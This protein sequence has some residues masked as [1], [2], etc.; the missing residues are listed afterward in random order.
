[1]A[2]RVATVVFSAGML[3]L[4]VA[5]YA[6]PDLP[7]RALELPRAEQRGRDRRR[8][9]DAPAAAPAP[10]VA[11]RVAVTVFAAGDTTYNVLTTILGQENPFP[12]LADVFYLAMYPI[13]AAGLVVLIRRRTGG[14]DRGS[15]LD[16]LSVTTA[17][18]LLSWIFLIDPYVRNPDLTW[19][20]RA[21][22]IAYPL[23]DILIMATLARLL[24]TA[25]RNRAALLLGAGAI[26]LLASDVVYGLG[27]L[28]GS[29]AIGSWYDLGW[30]VFYIAWGVAAPAPV[31]GRP[32]GPRA[33]AVGR[34]E[35]RAHRAADGGVA[36][37]S[38]RAPRRLDHGD[39]PHGPIIATSSAVL[40]LLVLAR[41]SGVVSRH[42]QAVERERT[43]RSAGDDLVSA[44]DAGGVSVAVRTAVARLLPATEHRAVLLV[45][46][47]A[48]GVPGRGL[49]GPGEPDRVRGRA[50]R[51][52]RARPRG[53]HHRAVVP[54]RPG[55]TGPPPGRPS[56]LLLVAADEPVL[57]TL[58]GALEVLAS[59]AALAIERMTLSQEV[60]RR[61][62]EAYFRTL[63]QN[64][65][66]VILIVDDG[67]RD[68]VRQPVRGADV[69]RR[70][71]WSA[72][73]ARPGRTRTDRDAAERRCSP[74]VRGGPPPAPTATGRRARRRRPASQVEV[75]CR[76]LRD[77]PT[78]RGLVVTLRDVTERRR[79]E[80][81]A[82]P[83]GV[84]RRAD[85]AGQPG[86]VP[87][88]GRAARWP[89][90]SATARVVGVLFIDLDDFKIVND[91]LGH[92]VGDEL[93]VAVGERLAAVRCAPATRRPGSAATSSPSLDR[94]RAPTPA[95]VEDDRRRASSP[96]SPSRSRSTAGRSTASVQ[97][98]RRH[99]APTASD[100]RRAAAPGR[101]RAVRRQGR[102]QGPVAALPAALHTAV[103]ERLELRDRAGPGG[104]RRR[105]PAALPAD[106]GAARPARRSASRRWCA[107]TTRPAGW[108]RPTSSSRWPRRAA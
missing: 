5:F 98:R 79:L 87:G 13:A 35:H 10:V 78:V 42:R 84:P 17:L 49:P 29:W 30:V 25:G 104:R 89:G 46:G 97:R 56:G 102:R 106:R 34:D 53:V 86:A 107:G 100:G 67:G 14:R 71:T 92:A 1:M 19:L 94:G 22:S 60:N 81:R 3:V 16:A 44:T 80:Q 93:L 101:P 11:A 69:R 47:E 43:L 77:D 50:R 64:T 91:T 90:P 41:L 38:G 108:S 31:D 21:T 63:V 8:G 32:H 7:P 33:G 70:A 68:P 59:Q 73:P 36:R 58:R 4:T 55:S 12:S 66:D 15:L 48:A 23:G 27:Q 72:R 95:E 76:D 105:V 99:H 20:E 51:D 61:N 103:L 85:R 75:A 62:S 96:R 18:A 6:F 39:V 74:L 83:P 24:I 52:G 40:F 65:A 82:D 45:D 57:L 37:G 26:G 88:P 28:E 54:A 9:A 2:T